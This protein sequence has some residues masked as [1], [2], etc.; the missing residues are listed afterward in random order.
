MSNV[1]H[2]SFGDKRSIENIHRSIEQGLIGVGKVMNDDEDL[3]RLKATRASKLLEDVLMGR[4][5]FQFQPALPADLTPHQ[6][7]LVDSAIV[8]AAERGVQEANDRCTRLF[9]E[10]FTDLCTSALRPGSLR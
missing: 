4:H 8:A 10:A 9:V 2:V 7:Q 5:T 3:M 1:I 6:R